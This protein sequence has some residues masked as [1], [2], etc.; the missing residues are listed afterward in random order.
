MMTKLGL[1]LQGSPI[2]IGLGF[3][4]SLVSF[5]FVLVLTVFQIYQ[6]WGDIERVPRIEANITTTKRLAVSHMGQILSRSKNYTISGEFKEETFPIMKVP[7]INSSISIYNPSRHAMTFLA[8]RMSAVFSNGSRFSSIGYIDSKNVNTPSAIG[9]Q[10]F[11]LRQGE[12]RVVDLSFFFLNEP[13]LSQLWANESIQLDLNRT[14]ISCENEQGE[15]TT[16]KS[17]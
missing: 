14:S 5:G 2:A 15:I 11:Y 16:S 3:L 4:G 6:L 12:A 10:A 1:W 8:C 13:Q 9:N 17:I 7:M